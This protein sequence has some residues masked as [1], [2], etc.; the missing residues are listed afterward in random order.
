MAAVSAPRSWIATYR[1]QLNRDFTLADAEKILPYLARLGISHVYL[2]PCLQ[3][4][5]GSQHGYDVTDPSRISEDLG[6][7]DAWNRFVASARAQSL[8]IL[9]D[10]VPNHMAATDQNPWWDDVL[11]HGPYSA[12]CRFFDIRLAVPSP[13]RVHICSLA[14]PYGEALGSGEL[15]IDYRDGSLRLHHYDNSWPLTPASWAALL[16]QPHPCFTELQQLT[17]VQSPG[18]EEIG[19]YRHNARLAQGL[20]RD[21]AADGLQE[22]VAAI[23]SDAERLDRLIQQQFYAVHGWKLAGE[24]VNYRRFFDISTLVGLS[25]EHPEVFAAA[26]GRFE[27]M[28]RGGEIAGLRVDHPDGLRDPY[29]YFRRLRQLLP[30]GRI[31]VEKILDTEERLPAGWAIDGTVGYDFLSKV[32]RLWMSDQHTDSLTSIYADFT[33]HSVNLGALIREKKDYIVRY[34]FAHDLQRLS[35]A[36]IRIARRSRLTSDLSPRQIRG[37][38]AQTTAA[39]GVYRTYRTATEVSDA[40]RSVIAEAVRNARF[41]RPDIEGAIFE[42]VLELLTR[43]PLNEEEFAFICEWQQLTP[44]VMAKG[45]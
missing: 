20:L 8:G 2:S 7:E 45:V 6:G 44:A 11:A 12:H 19:R 9:L 24:L 28:I 29:E 38:L 17:Q 13:F 10:I 32:N 23:N 14:R 39:L 18:E 31:Y 33:G 41:A 26:H 4:T 5:R 43:V 1:L 16:P 3:A 22:Q 42:F 37:A 36:A 15:K 35:D 34:A 27:R 40:D 21:A 30:A 25:T